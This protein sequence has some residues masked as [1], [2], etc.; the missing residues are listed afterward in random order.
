MRELVFSVTKKDF[1][2]DHFRAGGQGGQGQNKRSVGVRFTLPPSGAVGEGR[3]SRSRVE[4]ERNA[5]KRCISTPEF[6]L[7]HRKE[8]ARRAGEDALIELQVKESM[9]PKNLRVEIKNEE[10]KWVEM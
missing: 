1:R 6:K 7:W 9:R 8:I 5:F 3:D 2:I 10:G 4:N